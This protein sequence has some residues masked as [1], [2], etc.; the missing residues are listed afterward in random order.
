MASR[1]SAYSICRSR[2]PATG[3]D[4]PNERMLFEIR[5]VNGGWC[6]DSFATAGGQQPRC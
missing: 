1:R 4:I 5:I 2:D 6:L 3:A